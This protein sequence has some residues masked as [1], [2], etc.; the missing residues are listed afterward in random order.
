VK[1][2]RLA[3]QINLL[4][5]KLWGFS[6]LCLITPRV[7]IDQ[8]RKEGYHITDEDLTHI[9]PCRFDHINKH[10]KYTFNV[11]KELRRQ[12]LRALRKSKNP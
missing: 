2:E 9:S 6:P 8:L 12:I 1:K 10:G 4:T 3:C 7:V 5:K 11:E